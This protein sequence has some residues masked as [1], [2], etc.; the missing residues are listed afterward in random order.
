MG[1]FRFSIVLVALLVSAACA[2]DRSS[3]S[4]SPTAPSGAAS[5][6]TSTGASPAL[7]GTWATAAAPV[8]AIT[9]STCANL[10]WTVTTQTATQ[11]AGTFSAQCAGG[12]VLSGQASGQLGNSQTIPIVVQGT[13]SM[14]GVASCAFAIAGTG[15]IIEDGNALHVVYSGSTCLGPVSGAETFRKKAGLGDPPPPP[16]PP[17]PAPPPPPP[18][19]GDW[20]PDQM[21]LGQ[22]TVYNSPPDVAAWPITTKIT[23]LQMLG[24]SGG[25]APAFGAQS[26]W[27]DYTPPGWD[28]PLQYTFWAVV[29]VGGHWNT[30][31][32]IEFWRGRDNTGA[33]ILPLN[34]GFPVNWAYDSRWGP[35]NHYSPHVGEQMGFFVTAGDAR[36]QGGV[37]SLRE[38]SNV[39]MVNLPADY[40]LFTW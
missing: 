20:A 38:R 30:S 11:L 14:P 26:R 27:P 10:Q 7:L 31:G 22:A 35:M 4:Q 34:C 5:G 16:G 8:A 19:P 39:V 25:I 13:G 24:C 21:D 40:G 33:P 3:S 17:P 37:T 6:A 12:I 29:N 36:N 1:R 32:F 2:F 15:S 28:G 23:A 18:P 9:P